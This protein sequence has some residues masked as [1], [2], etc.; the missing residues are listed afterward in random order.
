M[1][2]VMLAE[3][4]DFYYNAV[5]KAIL[6]YVLKDDSEALRLGIMEVFQ[7]VQDYGENVYH[8]LEPDANW[9]NAVICAREEMY[10]KLVVCNEASLEIL[11]SWHAE[12]KQEFALL[13]LPERGA[14]P[15]FIADFERE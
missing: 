4:G 8:G 6:D 3:V 9:R 13:H 2:D 10:D 7:P 14:A 1:I 15:V 11:D 12:Y 5:R